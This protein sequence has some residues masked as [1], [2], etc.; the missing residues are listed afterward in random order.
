MTG[1]TPANSSIGIGIIGCGNICETYIR[2]LGK[3]PSVRVVACA[4]RNPAAASAMSAKHGLAAVSA[5]TLLADPEIQIVLN[6]TVPNAHAEVSRAIIS[7]GKHVYSEKPLA[8]SLTDALALVEKAA[9]CGVRIGC[10]PDTFL[11]GGHQ[12][13]RCLIDAGQIGRVIGGA[14]TM[15]TP[16]MERWHPNPTLFFQRGG[17]P[18]LDM[19]PYHITQVVNL[20]GPVRRVTAIATRGFAVRTIS[21]QPLAGAQIDV[22]VPTSLNGALEFVSGANIAVTFSW[23]IWKTSRPPLELYGENGTLRCPDPDYFGGAPS[24]AERDGE[25]VDADI[26]AWP[27]GLENAMAGNRVVA[28]Y[29]GVGVVDMAAAIATGRLHRANGALA[30]HVLEVLDA[31]LRSSDSGNAVVMKTGCERPAPL[32]R[33]SSPAKTNDISDEYSTFSA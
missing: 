29:R 24:F 3:W 22:E 7:A 32:A 27:F 10:A 5:D 26:S 17:G 31:L 11:G 6:L 21:S 23:D 13:A 14:I 9:A 33:P 25:W 18:T 28:N 16:G 8:T 30:L 1:P 4:D 2:G 12:A 19:G 15:A 20:L